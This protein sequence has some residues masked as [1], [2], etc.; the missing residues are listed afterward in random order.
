MPIPLYLIRLLKAILVIT[1]KI[2]HQKRESHQK[3]EK[4]KLGKLRL[5]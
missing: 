1:K 2:S 4:P 5:G 3:K